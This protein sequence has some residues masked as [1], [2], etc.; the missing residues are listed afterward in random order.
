MKLIGICK[1]QHHRHDPSH[2]VTAFGKSI[3]KFLASLSSDKEHYITEISSVKYTELCSTEI[4]TDRA[5]TVVQNSDP[6]DISKDME[7][8]LDTKCYA[9]LNK[10]PSITY[11]EKEF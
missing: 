11:T 2:F 5:S 6:V 9:S 8:L 7:T 3:P 4:S 1:K 10:S